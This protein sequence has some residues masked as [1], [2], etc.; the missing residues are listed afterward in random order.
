VKDGEGWVGAKL[1]RMISSTICELVMR[2]SYVKHYVII[3]LRVS[4]SYSL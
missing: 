2:V 4:I 1:Y 3:N